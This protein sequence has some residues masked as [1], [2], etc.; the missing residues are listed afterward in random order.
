MFI[1]LGGKGL[2]V[3]LWRYRC[4]KPE[5]ETIQAQYQGFHVYDQDNYKRNLDHN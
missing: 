5:S 3:D 2:N 4:S 1:G